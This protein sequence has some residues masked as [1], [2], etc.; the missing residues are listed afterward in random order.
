VTPALGQQPGTGSYRRVTF[1]TWAVLM[2]LALVG[3]ITI[4]PYALALNPLAL[5]PGAPPLALVLV[6]SVVQTLVLVGIAA[7]IGLWLGP[8]VGL[9]AP[10]LQAWL[11]GDPAAPRR[12]FRSLPLAAGLGIGASIVI[13]ALDA[14]VFAPSLAALATQPRE[15]EAWQGLLASLYGSIDEEILLRLG[16]MTLLVWLGARIT[17]ARGQP[18]P[19]VMWTANVLAA[20]LFGLG[21]L[22]ATAAVLPMTTLVIVRAIV[23]NGLAGVVFG[24]LYWRRGILAAMASHFCADL[25]LHVLTPLLISPR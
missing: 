23:L 3:A 13:V 21:H 8:K 17:R 10:D 12:F 2:L 9:G 20:V 5:P 1:K 11:A 7:A 22:P 6:A 15:P 19:A 4:L 14:F 25:V 18:G 16:L 24:W